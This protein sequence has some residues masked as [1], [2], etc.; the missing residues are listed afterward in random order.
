MAFVLDCSVAM[1]W[2]FPNEAT[3]ATD[4]LRE[5]LIEGRAVVP[6]LWPIEVGNALLVATRR[7]R[8]GVAEWPHIR[9]FVDALPIEIDSISASRTIGASL[10]LAHRH[11]LSLYDA[12]YLELAVRMLMPLATLDRA[13]GAA[14]KAAE[15]EVLNLV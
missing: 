3:E 11:E 13:L 8:V 5:S 4:R 9:E 15:I 6:C 14:G 10:D 1:A 7:G 12:M 2:I